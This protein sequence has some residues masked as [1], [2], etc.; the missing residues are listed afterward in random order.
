MACG[1]PVVVSDLPWV[2]ELIEPG[3]DALVVPIDA[4]AVADALRRIVGRPELAS[5]L[6]A[7]GRTLVETHRDATAEMDR[8]AAIYR[9]LVAR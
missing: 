3:R 8:L 9:S 1:C 5:A 6:G 4:G 7:S 2:H